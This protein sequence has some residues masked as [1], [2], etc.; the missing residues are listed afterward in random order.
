MRN[1]VVAPLLALVSL[2]LSAG[3][4][5]AVPAFAIQTDK[6]CQACHV[7]GFGP[8]LTPY[9]RDFKLHGYTERAERAGGFTLPFSAMAVASYVRTQKA[10]ASPPADGYGTND[11]SS[12]DQISLFL[13]G[14]I[15]SHLGGFVQTTYDGIAKA[16]TWDNLDLRAITTTKIKDKDVVLGLTLNNSPQ[17]Q[18]A[19]NTLPAWGFP[20]TSSKLS[21]APSASPLFN[22]ALAQNTLGLSAYAW[23]DTTYYAEFGAYGSPGRT[24]LTR[25]GADPF[26]PGDINNLAPYG[27]VAYQTKIGDGTVEVG[28]FGMSSSINPGRD[29]TT[30]LQDHYRDLG[31]D[32]SYQNA[33]DSGD[34]I[35]A[36]ARYMRE[37]QSL[38]ATCALGA[39]SP[40]DCS[41]DLNDLRAD[42]S[43]YWRDKVGATIAVFDTYGSANPALYPNSR[44]FK[45]DSSGVI[46][47]LD[48]TPWG[49]GKTPLGPRFN[50]RVGVQY[51]IY[52][53]FNGASKNYDGAG[54]NAS[55]NN[56][57]R[58]FTWVAY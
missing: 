11:N 14:G 34:V 37:R 7:G 57:L 21:P 39:G 41:T 55:D 53:R 42:A 24:T 43:Y 51:T 33:L 12:L 6:A 58:L 48:G 8:Q 30:G 26:N 4:A 9:G 54:S 40:G 52:S 50:I 22:G 16:W 32:A 36:D 31:L 46:L 29:Q 3:S 5:F 27:R 17:V 35:A 25:L 13:A 23:I 15:N 49:E 1:I 10:Q 20:F 47:Q 44:T 45:P 18:D 28:A 38:D 56:T 19:W 2:V